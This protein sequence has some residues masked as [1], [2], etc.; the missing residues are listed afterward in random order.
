MKYKSRTKTIIA[1]K[2]KTAIIIN[3]IFTAESYLEFIFSFFKKPFLFYYFVIDGFTYVKIRRHILYVF[4]VHA[5]TGK[6][7]T[8][9]GAP[10]GVDGGEKPFFLFV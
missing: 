9:T 4:T 7:V 1:F 5:P 3:Y 2:R 6:R 10:E 8:S